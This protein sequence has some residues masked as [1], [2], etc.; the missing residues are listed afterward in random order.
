MFREA[1]IARPH[2]RPGSSHSLEYKDMRLFLSSYRAGRH[3]HRLREM[4]GPI[5][6]V[7]V[8]TNAKDY[9]PPHERRA[10]VAENFDYYRSI[11]LEP[12]EIDLRPY[13]H[14]TGAHKLLANHEFIWL[15][16]GNAFLLR[17]ALAYSG[18]DKFLY[19]QVRWN[20]YILA[21][22]SAGAIVT[23]PTLRFSEMDA[24]GHEDSAAFISPGYRKEIIWE[25][26]D[27]IA[28]VPVPHYKARGYRKEVDRYLKLLERNSIPHK[29]MTDN[30]A[31]LINGAHE[32][33]LA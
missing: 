14:Q 8:I 13:F 21:G 33:F 28:F 6:K 26:L 29:A 27:F 23:G 2:I 5:S 7:A 4:L 20:E 32:E 25:G 30:Q 19:D 3:E 1:G 15:A 31:I 24:A 9:K 22:E 10:K 12:T 11:G 18:L 17:R 16:G